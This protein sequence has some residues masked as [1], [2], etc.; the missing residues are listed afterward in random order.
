MFEWAAMIAAVAF[1]IHALATFGWS[2]V[3]ANAVNDFME[4][5]K[6]ML[7]Y[8]RRHLSDQAAIMKA[9]RNRSNESIKTPRGWPP[10][11]D[12]E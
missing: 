5:Q 9:I 6:D 1:M 11:S 3:K 10:E 2:A 4:M 8:I 7:P 12:E